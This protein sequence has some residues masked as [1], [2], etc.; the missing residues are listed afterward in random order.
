MNSVMMRCPLYGQQATWKDWWNL[1]WKQ[2]WPAIWGGL[3]WAIGTLGYNLAAPKL[4]FAIAYIFGQSTPF[5]TSLYSIFYMKEFTHAGKRTWTYEITML[6][7]FAISLGCMCFA[8][9][10]WCVCS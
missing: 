4:G 9:P 10:E 6:V 1:T 5:V 3:S 8:L 7:A 2:R